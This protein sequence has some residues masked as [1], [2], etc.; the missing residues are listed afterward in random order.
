MPMKQHLIAAILIGVVLANASDA[1]PPPPPNPDEW[2]AGIAAS[3]GASRETAPGQPVSVTVKPI[4]VDDIG[5]KNRLG[6]LQFLWGARLSSRDARFG[7]ITA[8]A[9]DNSFGLLAVTDRGNWITIDFE[10]EKVG[11]VHITPMVGVN[12]KPAALL[13]GITYHVSFSDR[14]GI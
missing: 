9:L 5:G 10:P 4:L 8:I 13:K 7:G 1:A 6:K 14:T 3:C 2:Q 12:G 11:D